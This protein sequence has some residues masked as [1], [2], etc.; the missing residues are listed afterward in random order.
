[1]LKALSLLHPSLLSPSLLGILFPPSPPPPPPHLPSLPPSYTHRARRTKEKP[2][3]NQGETKE[4][5]RSVLHPE[6]VPLAYLQTGTAMWLKPMN[7]QNRLPQSLPI[8]SALVTKKKVAGTAIRTHCKTSGLIRYIAT[9]G[10]H[11]D[12]VLG[13]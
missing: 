13:G 4:K 6:T 10:P 11:R 8:G 9:T 3:R 7:T 12:S 1:M 5:P 2:R